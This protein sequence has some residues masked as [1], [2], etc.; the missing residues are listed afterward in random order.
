MAV[1][2]EE[3]IEEI[4]YQRIK[5]SPTI[6]YYTDWGFFEERR[7]LPP[8]EG[9]IAMPAWMKGSYDAAML[10]GD[11]DIRDHDRAL[12]VAV[13]PGKSL[14]YSLA[15][16]LTIAGVDNRMMAVHAYRW[17]TG[18]AVF[19]PPATIVRKPIRIASVGGARGYAGHHI[20][21]FAGRGS[22]ARVELYDAVPDGG[23][24]LKT[25]VVEGL[26]EQSAQLELH[27]FSKASGNAA[28]YHRKA[29]KV[30]AG[31]VL[32]ALSSVVGGGFTHY[33]EDYM[34]EETRSEARAEYRLVAS[35]TCR[36]DALSNAVHRGAAAKSVFKA[37][38]AAMDKGYLTHRGL[39]KV[40][41]GA[42]DAETDIDS[43]ILLLSREARANSVPMLEIETS[44]V[45]SARHAASVAS[46]EED[47]V[48]YMT[49]RG[50]GRDEVLVLLLRDLLEAGKIRVPWECG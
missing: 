6:K 3:R 10:G 14:P 41:S 36:L 9:D 2:H 32:Q 27:T 25:I 20:L 34:L 42:R 16:P 23:S 44:E 8:D 48:F 21:V 37:R 30:L 15:A 7:R 31:G 13:E 22:R 50:L 28:L 18:V 38:G 40:L 35:G 4:P 5:D 29:V 24:G 12:L 11:V 46:L 33:R 19:I 49:S 45:A 26:V 17:S 39:I 47:Q 43:F 1:E